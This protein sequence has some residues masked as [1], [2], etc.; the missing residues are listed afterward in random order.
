M[1]NPFKKINFLFSPLRRSKPHRF[2]LNNSS[3]D[4][5][6]FTILFQ[7]F[8]HNS[9]HCIIYIDQLGN[10]PIK[11]PI[12]QQIKQE[13]K[14]PSKQQ[15]KQPIKQPIKQPSKQQIKQPSKQLIKQPI[16]QLRNQ[17]SNQLLYQPINKTI[18]KKSINRSLLFKNRTLNS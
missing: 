6:P 2:P 3:S 14:G 18:S 16:K 13:I 7:V 9:A 1:D 17:A 15:S 11:Q 10:Q 12:K 4:L 5:Q 8:P